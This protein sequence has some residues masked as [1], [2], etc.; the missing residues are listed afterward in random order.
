LQHKIIAV[1]KFNY[2]NVVLVF[3]YT[4]TQLSYHCEETIVW[5]DAKTHTVKVYT[6]RTVICRIYG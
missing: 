2:T 4:V 5:N 6:L 1:A 3:S